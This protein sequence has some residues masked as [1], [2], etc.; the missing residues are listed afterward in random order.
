MGICCVGRCLFIIFIFYMDG[1][2][3]VIKTWISGNCEDNIE[4]I[5]KIIS[6]RIY[7]KER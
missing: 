4:F 1:I 5:V 7:K 3:A 6:E 2:L